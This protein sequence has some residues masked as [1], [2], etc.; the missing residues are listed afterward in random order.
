MSGRWAVSH[1][2]LFGAFIAF[3][4]TLSSGQTAAEGN[5]SAGSVPPESKLFDIDQLPNSKLAERRVGTLSDEEAAKRGFDVKL[6]TALVK[7]TVGRA[8]SN[9]LAGAQWNQDVWHFFDSSAHFDNCA[10][11]ASLDYV[12]TLLAE[13]DSAVKSGNRDAALKAVGQTLHAIQDFYAHSN[14]IELSAQDTPAFANVPV[15]RI[16]ESSGRDAVL[17]MKALRSGLWGPSNP[18]F[19]PA[20]S[21]THSQLAKDN[22]GTESGQALMKSWGI[23]GYVAAYQMAERASEDFLKWAYV[24]WPYLEQTCGPVVGF[25]VVVDRR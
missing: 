21:K 25:A 19:C 6:H 22:P 2:A 24:K 17:G 1:R 12:D 4:L 3:N 7:G 14:Y 10:F 8:C 18:K 13:V 5:G 15:L 20:G 16:W 9:V 11:G 23:T